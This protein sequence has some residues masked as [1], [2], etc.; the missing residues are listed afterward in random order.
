MFI[1][2]FQHA[3]DFLERTQSAL[4][5]HE[6][7]NSLMLGLAFRLKKNPQAYKGPVYM[8]TVED[9]DGL[10]LAA[11]M[12]TPFNLILYSHRPDYNE[13]LEILILDLLNHQWSV[14]GVSGPTQLAA[15]FARV[16]NK[17]TG[18]SYRIRTHERIFELHKVYMPTPAPGKMRLATQADMQIVTR[19]CT[20]FF[21]EALPKER[22]ED[23]DSYVQQRLD[24]KDFYLWELLDGQVVSL[25]G[26]TRPVISVI[27]IGPVYTPPEQRGHGYASNLVA[28]LSQH[29]LDAG[30]KSCS[31]F[32]DLANPTSNAIYRRIGYDP[33]I[34]WDE[35]HFEA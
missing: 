6:A 17:Q 30:W 19:Y 18:E 23:I 32:T 4:L 12:T 33:L 34:D 15:D 29:L 24:N 35:Y 25:A 20:D 16:W 26:K 21:I 10:I 27:S 13:A 22:R 1:A 7:A 2:T 28:T 31:L 5:E 8:G 3:H 14:P 9:N 11:L